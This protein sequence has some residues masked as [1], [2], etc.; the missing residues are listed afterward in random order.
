[1]IKAAA[2]EVTELIRA[3]REKVYEAW[4]RPELMK[5]WFCPENLRPGQ[6]AMDVRVGGAYRSEMVGEDETYTATGV[7]QEIVLNEKLVFT[8]GWEGPDRV[9]TRVTVLF[10]DKDHGTEVTVIHERLEDPE[11]LK[12]HKEGWKSTLKNLGKFFER[13]GR[14]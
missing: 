13:D 14:E 10:K 11:S 8:H 7:Y 2:L 9:E 4:I 12:G 5:K 6:V 3:K 1:M